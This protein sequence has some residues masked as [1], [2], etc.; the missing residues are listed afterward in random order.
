MNLASIPAVVVFSLGL[1]LL[2]RSLPHYQSPGE[3]S[4]AWFL[5]AILVA[6][7]VHEFLHALMARWRCGFPWNSFEFGFNPKFLIFYC[8][9]R[10][11]L[12]LAAYRMVC[13]GPLAVLGPFSI[14]LVVGWPSDWLA[15]TAG[16]HLAGCLGDVWVFTLLR[17]YPPDTLVMDHPKEIGCDLYAPS[18]SPA[19][20]SV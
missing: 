18:V 15:H 16:V 7:A 14:A 5:P 3:F 17:K 4:L 6:V 20:Q 10:R 19:N 11:P 1:I 2:A 9:P 13:L 8:H 12:N